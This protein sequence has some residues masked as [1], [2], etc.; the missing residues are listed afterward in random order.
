MPVE[1]KQLATARDPRL[2]WQPPTGLFP[3]LVVHPKDSS[4]KSAFLC[5]VFYLRFENDNSITSTS[6]PK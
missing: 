5:L 3:E 4:A 1:S 6:N 2:K